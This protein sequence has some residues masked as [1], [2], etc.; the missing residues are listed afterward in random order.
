MSAPTPSH[1]EPLAK[2]S[3]PPLD[4]TQSNGVINTNT[5]ANSGDDNRSVPHWHLVDL[6][7]MNLL[8]LRKKNLSSQLN[9]STKTNWYRASSSPFLLSKTNRASIPK[10]RRRNDLTQKDLTLKGEEHQRKPSAA[11]SLLRR[12]HRHWSNSS[13]RRS[14]KH[15]SLPTTTTA[16]TK[17][18]RLTFVAQTKVGKNRR[19]R[20]R[21]KAKKQHPRPPQS[22]ARVHRKRPLLNRSNFTPDDI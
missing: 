5:N 12:C 16:K 8:R 7:D 6:M 13:R 9:S 22:S 19:Q 20:N 4:R 21:Q 11:K 2:K 1:N 14:P 10:K 15:H 17:T 18:T 3:P